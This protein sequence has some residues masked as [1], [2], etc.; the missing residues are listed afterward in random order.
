MTDKPLTIHMFSIHGLVRARN[1]E[2]GRDADTGGQVKYVVEL[3]THL[4]QLSGVD[5]VRLFTRRINDK[6]VSADYAEKFEPVTDK[7]AIVRIPCGG[8]K[9]IRKELLWPH[10]DEFVD[11]TIKYI[12][13][14]N[15]IPDIVHGHYPDGGYAAMQLSRIFGI[16]F[17]YTGH[18]LGRSKLQKLLNDGMNEK[19]I[20]RKFKI[21]YR[22]K[23][24][25]DVLQN[26][27][28]V[29]TSTSHEIDEQYAAYRNHEVPEY[30]VIP[31][32]LDVEKFYPYYRD[33]LPEEEKDPEAMYAEASV[34]QE[35]NRFF[36]QPDKPLILA[37]CRPDKR[38]NI[39]GLVKAFGEDKEL[40]TMANL[41]IFAGIR[42]DIADMEDNE[43]GVLT[44][45]LLLMDKYDLYGK[46][47]IPK[48]HESEH[49]VPALYRITAAR[50][51]VFVNPALTEPFGLTLLEAS[52]AGVP[53][54]S[55]KEGGPADIMENCQNGILIDPTDTRAIADAIKEIITDSEK[56]ETFSKNG[57]MNV[58]EHYT[59][60]RHAERYLEEIQDLVDKGESTDLTAARPAD[61][62]GRR[63]SGINHLFIT[64]ID[65]TLIGE[66]N[67][68][69]PELLT[70][71]KENRDIVGFCAAT[72]RHLESAA[73]FLEEH[74]VPPPDIL[75]TSV[76]TEIY[77]GE[78]HQYAGGWDTHISAGW[79]REKIVT[80]L[81]DFDFLEYQPEETQRRFKASWYMKPGKDRLARIHDTLTRNKCRY[82]LI[83]S[84]DRDLD[85]LPYRASKGK[86]IR[87]ISYKWEIPLSNCLVCGDTGND[88][89]MLRGE[90]LG[91]VVANYS[92]E[93]NSLK[94]S[95]RVYFAKSRLAGGILEAME[96][97]GFIEK[98]RKDAR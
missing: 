25:E 70:L 21:D 42:K 77:Y 22:I 35:L 2:L 11:E 36:S 75:I 62:I 91:V 56:W 97:Y 74:G 14:E 65:N 67:P 84:S 18:S 17:V 40:I 61:T 86:A 96:K 72:G 87:Y 34:I 7:F 29:I 57:I 31:P 26:A 51:G 83:Y 60:F 6:T 43:R 95:R 48:Q 30:R 37:L 90:P 16:P 52:S 53:I 94:K 69:L 93:L 41:A 44:D 79:H 46:M 10:M 85:I 82:N 80:L 89:E 78:D 58:R 71:L 39:G 12:K 28:V 81:S 27:D 1:M 55:T 49:E 32:G 50:R 66:D 47:A 54:V 64:D 38:K 15:D 63:L 76:G 23:V 5:R 20:I 45:M 68:R 92:P 59:W 88:E 9:Y 33:M 98:A 13:G 4:A 24:E 19:E 8:R 73:S 3:C